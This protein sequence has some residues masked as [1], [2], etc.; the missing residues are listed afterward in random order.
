MVHTFHPNTQE[1]EAGV[2]GQ[3]TLH[4]TR[5]CQGGKEKGK[6]KAEMREGGEVWGEE[7]ER[8]G[9][10]GRE[11]GE[12]EERGERK[13]NEEGNKKLEK[14]PSGLILCTHVAAH[15]HP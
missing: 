2:Q 8:G 6:E 13:G 5:L 14:L 1:A 11:A 10:R 7:G 9:R 3:P 4:L 15:N 12:G